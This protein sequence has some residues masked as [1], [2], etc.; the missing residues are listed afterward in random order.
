MY[1]YTSTN[2]T[3]FGPG[4]IFM[5]SAD[6][7][8]LV[9]DTFNNQLIAV[10]QMFLG[11]SGSA[12]YDKI[13]VA[14]STDWGV[15]WSHPVPINLSGHP[16]SVTRTFDPTITV[17]QTGQYRLFFT[18][19]PNTTSLDST[20]DT[21]SA[22]SSD[23]INFTFETNPR[24]GVTHH[25]VIDPAVV[26]WNSAWHYTAPVGAPQDGAYY[27]RSLG[28]LNFT[29]HDTTPSNIY[30]NWT[31]NLMDNVSD[32]R[33]YGY[34]TSNDPVNAY[35]VWWSSSIDGIT[36]V[37]QHFT[38]VKGKDPACVLL[39][40]GHYLMV[41][42]RDTS[43]LGPPALPPPPSPPALVQ[44]TGIETV[45]EAKPQLFP[46]PTNGSI[47]F[48]APLTEVSSVAL[49]SLVGAHVATIPTSSTIHTLELP[50]LAPGS[51]VLRVVDATHPQGRVWRIVAR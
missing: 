10:F 16:G 31:G 46:N 41:A 17:S 37:G 45:Q 43:V 22:I 21:Y 23:A 36:W 2:G 48:S 7:P 20:C 32:M 6:V 40:N 28:G 13:G 25:Q 44:A 30:R 1:Q 24:F 15:S 47:G 18:Y 12:T 9:V 8:S 39:P 11:G 14:F 35:K 27:A 29:L 19:C 26:L 51:Y 42:P 33:F 3:H 5:D 34:N 38:N 4:H 50:Q 49:F